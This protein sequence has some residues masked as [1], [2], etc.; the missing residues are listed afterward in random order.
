MRD[1]RRDGK[2]LD[3]L[4]EDLRVFGP[5]VAACRQTA[6]ALYEMP[7]F[8]IDR[9]FHLLV[10]RHRRLVRVDAYLHTTIA[11]DDVDLGVV[12]GI[13]VTTP[14]R[15]LID[16][17]GPLRADRLRDLVDYCTARKLTSLDAIHRRLVELR[18]SG[19]PGLNK[20]LVALDRVDA[21]A[22]TSWL[23]REFLRLVG[24]AGLP[25][26]LTEQV[27]ARRGT[28]LVRVDCHFPG[29]RVVVEL[30]GYTFH[31]TVQQMSVDAERLNALQRAGYLVL[32]FTYLH[33]TT[34]PALVISELT[35]TLHGVSVVI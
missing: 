11:F 7:R 10:P 29:T 15:T 33:V 12:A 1:V 21:A 25:R 24:Q 14:A 28:H 3:Q 17:A 20:L 2:L 9:P 13:A 22:G 27:L 32:Q 23:E 19:R 5:P 8:P 26:P 35:R 6:A 16:L 4:A 30:L 18:G 31:R 34:Q